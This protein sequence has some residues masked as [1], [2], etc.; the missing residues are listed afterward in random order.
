MS[1]TSPLIS[2]QE[3]GN[4]NYASV[5]KLLNN[6]EAKIVKLDDL[7]VSLGPREV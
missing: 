6:T 5:G 1:E 7:S 4:K 2:L 3:R